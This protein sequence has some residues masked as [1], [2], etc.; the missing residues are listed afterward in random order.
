VWGASVLGYLSQVLVR[1]KTEPIYL[2]E[3][4]SSLAVHCAPSITYGKIPL[5]Y[6]LPEILYK[7][8]GCNEAAITCR[9]AVTGILPANRPGGG[10]D[11]H[12]A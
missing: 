6:Y 3:S 9:R 4:R 10:G 8:D 2:I 12:F 7:R 1:V 5:H 11:S